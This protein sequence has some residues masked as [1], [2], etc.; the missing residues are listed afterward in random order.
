ME[1]SFCEYF[2]RNEEKASR[3]EGFLQVRKCT[4]TNMTNMRGA[5]IVRLRSDNY[6]GANDPLEGGPT[7]TSVAF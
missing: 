3:P 1:A 7:Q 6:N 4:Q 5:K 2:L